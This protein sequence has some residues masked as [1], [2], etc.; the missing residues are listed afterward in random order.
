MCGL[1]PRLGLG[2]SF[3]EQK[4]ML[5]DEARVKIMLLS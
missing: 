2:D 1:F 5:T 3:T 4:T